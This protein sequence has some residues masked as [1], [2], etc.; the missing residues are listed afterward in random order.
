MTTEEQRAFDDGKQGY[1]DNLGRGATKRK[2]P[3]LRAAWRAGWDEQQRLTIA[4]RATEEQLAEG[5]SVL[6]R[7]KAEISKLP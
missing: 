6:A 1:Q 3:A 2:N 5:R 4:N 7:L